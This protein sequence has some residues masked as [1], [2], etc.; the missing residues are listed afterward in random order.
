[1]NYQYFIEDILLQL[2]FNVIT[3]NNCFKS[4]YS[5]TTGWDLDLPDVEFNSRTLVWLHFQDFVTPG[6]TIKELEKVEQ[7]YGPNSNQVLVTYWPHG[8]PKYYNGP[9]NLIEYSSHN[10]ETCISISRR[11]SEW[12][13]HFKMRA[14]AWQSLNGRKTPHRD[15][16]VDILKTWPDGVLSYGSEIPLPEWDYSTYRGTENDENFVRLAP[17]YMN[18]RVNIVTETQYDRPPGIVS[19]KTLQAMIACQ[20]PIVIGHQ[21]IVRDCVELGFDMFDDIVDTSY[22]SLPNETR[23]EQ[24]LLLNKDVILGKASLPLN[25]PERLQEQRKYVLTTYPELIDKRF[26]EQATALAKKLLP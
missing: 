16:V 17:I 9:I 21:G 19:E 14:T 3:V 5:E 4:S 22:D 26:N 1:M 25:L 2:S 11:M 13:P 7:K 12:Q 10:Y 18:T 23:V 20:V 15:R 6:D 24:A 8:L